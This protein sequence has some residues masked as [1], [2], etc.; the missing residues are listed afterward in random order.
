MAKLCAPAV[1]PAT[2]AQIAAVE[3]SD[4][5]YAIGVVGGRLARQPR[6]L[7]EA[8]ATAGMLAANGWEYSVGLVQINQKH[9]AQYGLTAAAAFDP[10]TNLRVGG[11][12]FLDCLKRAGNAANPMGDAL[13]CYYSGNFVAGY[14]LGYV[15]RVMSA[16][17]AQSNATIAIP[18]IDMNAKP[19]RI[20][21]ADRNQA[22]SVSAPA[23]SAQP[24]VR[25]AGG[26]SRA[27][28]HSAI[29]F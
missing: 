5:P 15:E 1:A 27:A 19:R 24:D 13:S 29:L 7:V 28:E 20:A 11:M 25:Q 14:R 10:C 6:S 4:N 3:S 22:P 18:V 21:A 12:I 16:A 8:V 17:T 26:S 9:F 23:A 2:L